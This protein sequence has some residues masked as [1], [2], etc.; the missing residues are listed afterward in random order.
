MEGSDNGKV[1]VFEDTICIRFNDVVIDEME[2]MAA[3]YNKT[4][5]GIVRDAVVIQ[6]VTLRR[7]FE[8]GVRL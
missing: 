8:D 5:S 4:I 6:M 1:T 7:L 2:K 3:R